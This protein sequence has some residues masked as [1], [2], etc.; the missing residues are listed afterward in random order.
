M[1]SQEYIDGTFIDYELLFAQLAPILYV[2]SH[3]IA[4]GPNALHMPRSKLALIEECLNICGK[5][6]VAK[7][8]RITLASQ[9]SIKS[10]DE[11][12]LP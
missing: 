7:L 12:R 5:D 8:L 11:E 3:G 1:S 2:H 6:T 4:R 10:E 9:T